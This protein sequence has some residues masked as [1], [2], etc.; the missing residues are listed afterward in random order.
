MAISG[1][2][3]CGLYVVRKGLGHQAIY[4]FVEEAETGHRM[5]LFKGLPVQLRLQ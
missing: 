3:M 1:D 5:P 2:P 4:N